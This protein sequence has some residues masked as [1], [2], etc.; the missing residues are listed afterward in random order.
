M[1]R[2]PV[3]PAH[4]DPPPKVLLAVGDIAPDRSDPDECFEL[5][6]EDLGRADLVFCQLEVVLTRGGVRLPQARHTIR[7][8]P[9]VAGALRR[10]NFGVVSLAGNHCMDWGAGALLETEAHL[11]TENLTVLGAGASIR[12]ARRPAI[13]AVGD[14]TVAFLAYSS[15]LP[16]N[17]WA[18]EN[19]AGC[20]PMRAWTQ[21]EQIEHD[22]P[23]TPARIH[24]FADRADLKALREDI[25]AARH[26]A[27]IVIVSLHWGIH[28]VPAVIADY[29]REVGH[30]A[31]DAGA[32]AILGH[33]AHILKGVEVYRERP[34]FYSLGNFAID[35]RMDRAH[36]QSKGFKEI[37][38]LNP[39]WIPDFDSLYNFPED[40]R[41]TMVVKFTMKNARILRTSVLPAYINRGAQPRIL[42]TDEPEFD[43]VVEYL[44]EVSR[45]AQLPVE[46]VPSSGELEIRSPPP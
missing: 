18:E 43:Q 12:E 13:R 19:R 22:Q 17:Y 11:R 20:A 6:R 15:I 46:F 41:K 26:R 38:A 2:D 40:S 32:D 5:V 16:S 4:A 8:N 31:I 39:D 34:I 24:T 1:N 25:L 30:A 14:S 42:R 33:H 28:F 27:D 36:A 44:R 35:L 9:A 45:R 3:A 7:G 29:Q 21:Y 23:G 10:A 37:Q